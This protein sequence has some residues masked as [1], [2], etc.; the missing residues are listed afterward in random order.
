LDD[1]DGQVVN[2]VSEAEIAFLELEERVNVMTGS[3]SEF[4]FLSLRRTTNRDGC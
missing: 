1:A 2:I 3:L 4:Q